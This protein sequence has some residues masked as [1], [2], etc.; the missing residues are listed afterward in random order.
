MDERK[1][2]VFYF[3]NAEIGKEYKTTTWYRC[4]GG[5]NFVELVEKENEIVGVIFSD[6]NIGFILEPKQKNDTTQM[7]QR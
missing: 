1:E 2:K 3:E 4:V 7:E 5:Q 6:N